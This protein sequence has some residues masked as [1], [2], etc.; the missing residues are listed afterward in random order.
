GSAQEFRPPPVETRLT[1]YPA[2][3]AE[4][5]KQGLAKH[6]PDAIPSNA[7]TVKLSHFPGFLQGG[8]WL[9]L[10]LTLPPGTVAKAYE[11]ASKRAKQFYDG[12]DGNDRLDNDENAIPGPDFVTS[13]D[14]VESFPA[15]YRIFIHYGRSPEDAGFKWNHGQ[16]YGV[17]ISR[18]R[19]E[20]IYFAINW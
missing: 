11:D 16:S 15:D 17:V 4:W 2:L 18:K 20:V 1:K 6:F 5:R 9:Q 13:D 19:N 12:G 3:L 7:T 8:A 10:R 14:K